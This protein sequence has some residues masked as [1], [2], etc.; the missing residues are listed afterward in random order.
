MQLSRK[1]GLVWHP[2]S[3]TILT[4]TVYLLMRGV[5]QMCDQPHTDCGVCVCVCVCTRAHFGCC[6]FAI[7]AFILCK[8]WGEV[9][10]Y[11]K[12]EKWVRSPSESWEST[13]QKAGCSWSYPHNWLWKHW[14][15]LSDFSIVLNNFI[16]SVLSALKHFSEIFVIGYISVSYIKSMRAWTTSF[17][18]L[19]PQH[20]AWRLPWWPR[21]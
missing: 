13:F 1:M 19:N 6:V 11:I 8:E 16:N 15:L 20:L 14:F 21:W 10:L 12:A 9:N 18:L 2:F 4:D 3:Y 7:G 17:Y 5:C